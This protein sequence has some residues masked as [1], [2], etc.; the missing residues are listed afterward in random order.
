M[1]KKQDMLGLFLSAVTFVFMLSLILIRTF[2]P[3]VILPEINAQ[4]VILLSLAAL[5]LEH[6]ITHTKRQYILL[7]VYSA[8]IF[9]IFP[10]AAGLLSA[11]DALWWALLGALICT[12]LAFLFELACDRLSSSPASKLAPA[13]T[14][15]G[16][17]LACQCI[18]G[19]I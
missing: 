2:L 19:I 14:A 6:Y 1:K 16:L 18:I 11:S 15:F 5:T 10:W 7:F 12:A 3:R 13:I 17:Y 9:G 8:V 4:A